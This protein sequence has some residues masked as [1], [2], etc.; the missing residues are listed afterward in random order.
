MKNSNT[1]NKEE[2]YSRSLPNDGIE[3]IEIEP[4][5]IEDM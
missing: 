3:E 4:I 2:S 1:I 5:D